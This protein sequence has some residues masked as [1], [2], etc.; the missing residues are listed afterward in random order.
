M[1]V[2]QINAVYKIR[3]TGRIVFELHQFLLKNGIESY[4]ACSDGNDSD[5]IY[6]IGSDY[7]KKLHA[8]M[9]RLTGLQG[10]FSRK[11]T[12]K[13][14]K[15]VEQIKPDIVHLGNLHANYVNLPML[16]RY[17][18]QH[19]IGTVITL[20]DCWFFT[21]KCMHYMVVKCQKW[22]EGCNLCPQLRVDNKS[23][24]FDRTSKIWKDK[25]AGIEAI[26]RLAVIGVS[27]W[28]TNE[29]RGS[30]LGRAKIIRRIYNWIDLD[31]FRYVGSDKQREEWHLEG[32]FVILGVANRWSL[33]KGLDMFIR[34][35]EKIESNKRIVLVGELPECR[36]PGNIIHIPSTNQVQK[37]V[38]Y[39]SMADVFL[40]LSLE[41]T[42]GKVTAEALAC[43]TP[44]I[45]IDSTA[46]GELVS[47]ACGVILK[48]LEITEIVDALHE[49]EKHGKSY[50]KDT[51]REFAENN[52]DL[53]ERAKDYVNIYQQLIDMR[54]ER[55]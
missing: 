25:K 20:H 48:N 38:K 31:T 54:N 12:K 55:F 15:Y 34:L 10:Y 18:A 49:V 8:L 51:C 27:D 26:P 29:A 13:L 41:E 30:L 37:L 52:F 19:D 42:F 24:F 40:Q 47:D 6:L 32:R 21:G 5:E 35:A 53:I 44:V 3:S 9:S 2:L 28:I 50:Y 45:T 4:V 1:K 43:G 7:E 33:R 11:G 14:I 36:L 39:Y 23:W 22:K 17:L 46:N 16:L